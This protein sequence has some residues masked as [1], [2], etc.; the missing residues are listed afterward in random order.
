MLISKT[1]ESESMAKNKKGHS[2]NGEK[3]KMN[4]EATIWNLYAP[5]NIVW[6]IQSH[7]LHNFMGKIGKP[8]HLSLADQTKG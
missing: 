1:A 2:I 5:N 3:V 4:Q 7:N 6:R 8:T